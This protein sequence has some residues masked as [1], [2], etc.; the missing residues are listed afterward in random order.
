MT[1]QPRVGTTDFINRARLLWGQGKNL[2]TIANELGCDVYELSPWVYAPDLESAIAGATRL[3]RPLGGNR[4]ELRFHDQWWHRLQRE[5]TLGIGEVV[6]RQRVWEVVLCP[7]GIH[8]TN[9]VT[10]DGARE[11]GERDARTRAKRDG[12]HGAQLLINS[13]RVLEALGDA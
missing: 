4:W 6:P 8:V 10:I 13:N 1:K 5:P 9:R 12:E 3:W 2:G 11:A 7:M